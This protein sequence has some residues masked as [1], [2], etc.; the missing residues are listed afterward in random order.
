MKVSREN[1][2]DAFQFISLFGPGPEQ[3]LFS[4]KVGLSIDT[5]ERNINTRRAEKGF[6]AS[7]QISI[8]ACVLGRMG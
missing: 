2:A 6:V 1:I 5:S 3:F 8:C 4:A 7:M